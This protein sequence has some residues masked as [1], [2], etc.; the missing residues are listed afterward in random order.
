M[1]YI[2]YKDGKITVRSHDKQGE[3]LYDISK[4]YFDECIASKKVYHHTLNLTGSD[5]TTLGEL[6]EV[7]GDLYLHFTRLESLGNLKFVE[8]LIHCSSPRWAMEK[9]I[10]STFDLLMNSE[11]KD[12]MSVVTH[13]THNIFPEP[14]PPHPLIERIIQF[15]KSIFS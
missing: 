15:I 2:W 6:E 1:K 9:E 12:K 11:F 3:N 13:P 5:I 7:H 10:F 8:G 4:E 14:T